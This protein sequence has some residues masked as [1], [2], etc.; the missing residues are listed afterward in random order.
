MWKCKENIFDVFEYLKISNSD[1][2][3]SPRSTAPRARSYRKGI[4]HQ[5]KEDL[6]HQNLSNH[7]TGYLVSQCLIAKNIKSQGRVAMST[8][9][10]EQ[11]FKLRVTL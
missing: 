7:E 3:R 10:V 1:Q 6:V 2:E 11:A 5:R 8:G 9:A 4:L